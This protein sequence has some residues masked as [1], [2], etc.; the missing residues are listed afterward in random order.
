M[1]DLVIKDWDLEERLIGVMLML[2]G[3]VGAIKE[4]VQ[5]DDFSNTKL[6]WIY[7]SI[8]NTEGESSIFTVASDLKARGRETVSEEYL[9]G[10]VHDEL[11]MTGSITMARQLVELS[12]RRQAMAT[13]STMAKLVAPGDESWAGVLDQL[14]ALSSRVLGSRLGVRERPIDDLAAEYIRQTRLY[15]DDPLKPGEVR[16]APTGIWSLDKVMHGLGTGLYLVGAVQHTG[17]TALTL[18]IA[19]NAASSGHDAVVYS[20]EHPAEHIVERIVAAATGVSL[21]SRLSGVTSDAEWRKLSEQ[22]EALGRLPLSIIGHRMSLEDLAQDIRARAKSGLSVAVVDNIEVLAGQVPGEQN[23]IA[24]QQVAYSLL[25]IAQETGVSL[26]TTMQIGEKQLQGKDRRPSTGA[27][28]GS[29]GP[30][31]A[32]SV[33]WLLHRPA[34]WNEEY[35]GEDVMEII[36]K[37][38]KVFYTGA[39]RV[40]RVQLGPCGEIRERARVQHTQADWEGRVG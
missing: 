17:K 25:T 24:Y 18:Q 1:S 39:N 40:A 20:F 4:V 10:L 23:Y 6:R 3:R 32:A 29:S 7:Q 31:Q 30:A 5:A 36:C 22:A 9:R 34:L 8:I 19:V 37:K 16:G 13:L 14:R 26:L 2:P 38:D 15:A 27:L 21:A 28:Y 33:I 35:E 11:P 12:E